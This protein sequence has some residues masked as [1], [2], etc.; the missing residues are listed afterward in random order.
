VI[1]TGASC[2]ARLPQL[3]PRD[4]GCAN[5]LTHMAESRSDQLSV[6][7]RAASIPASWA[8]TM[9]A[10]T[11]HGNDSS[12]FALLQRAGKGLQGAFTEG[13][14]TVAATLP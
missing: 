3:H 8:I 12:V 1:I 10:H 11:R 5:V 2:G 7:L 13:E 14:A 4:H 9:L 6:L